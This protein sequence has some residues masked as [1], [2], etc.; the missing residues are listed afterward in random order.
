VQKDSGIEVV[1]KLNDPLILKTMEGGN[2]RIRISPDLTG[3]KPEAMKKGCR[4]ADG[5][6]KWRLKS[7]DGG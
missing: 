6:R 1:Y 5:G 3:A 4:G 2:H 7:H